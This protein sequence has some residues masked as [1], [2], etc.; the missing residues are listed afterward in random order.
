M[1][2][3]EQLIAKT[4][5]EFKWDDYG[6][7]DFPVNEEVVDHLAVKIANALRGRSQEVSRDEINKGLGW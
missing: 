7:D 3:A 1:T 2:L 6:L 5:R 4:I